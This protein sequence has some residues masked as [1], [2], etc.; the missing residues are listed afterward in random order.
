MTPSDKNKTPQAIVIWA[1][2]LSFAGALV[3][4]RITL[5][6]KTANTRSLTAPDAIFAWG[7]Y[8]VPIAIVLSLRWLVIPRLREPVQVMTVFIV[9]IAFAEVLTFF[10]IFLFQPQFRLFYLT[11]WLLFVQMMP[12]WTLRSDQSGG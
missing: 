5:V 7:C 10:G 12:M 4:Y 6:G 8:I 11:S 2:W 9:G 1:L 3:M